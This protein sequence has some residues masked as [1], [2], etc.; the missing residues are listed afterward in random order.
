MSEKFVQTV[1]SVNY[2]NGVFSL[3]FVGQDQ[4]KLMLGKIESGDEQLVLKQTI[5]LP[6]AGFMYM[7]SM[8]KNM[9]EDSRMEKE[10]ERLIT[11]GMIGAADEPE[12]GGIEMMAE[13]KSGRQKK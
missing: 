12:Q 4:D 5:H 3:H 1:S 6:A 10:F 9:L 8:I 2:N 11:V 13:S 7:V